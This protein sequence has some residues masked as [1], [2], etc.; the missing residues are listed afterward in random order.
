MS[1]SQLFEYCAKHKLLP[2]VFTS[3]LRQDNKWISNVA[4]FG[5]EFIC[6]KD[7]TFSKKIDAENFVSSLA[8]ESTP[9][10]NDEQ[11]PEKPYTL[12]EDLNN[13]I[14]CINNKKI[15][16]K[17]KPLYTWI[18]SD[19]LN[20]ACKLEYDIKLIDLENEQYRCRH[21][22]LTSP[23]FKGWDFEPLELIKQLLP[24]FVEWCSSCNGLNT[25]DQMYEVPNLGEY[26][27]ITLSCE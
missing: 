2:P 4:C 5:K 21:L 27:Q 15:L 18:A 17:H 3:W 8:L 13:L 24:P 16:A 1:K 9:Y 23:K 7:M 14:N 11:E 6:D 20:S 25:Y 22:K 10:V 26:I 12:N 19:S